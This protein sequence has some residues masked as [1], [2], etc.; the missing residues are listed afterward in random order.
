MSDAAVIIVAVCGVLT[1]ATTVWGAVKLA[2][3][4]NVIG[5]P[6][7]GDRDVTVAEQNA[8]LL[9]L[10]LISDAKL[11]EVAATVAVVAKK[12][13]VIPVIAATVAVVAAKVD[14]KQKGN[15]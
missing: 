8:A 9:E 15:P 5:T 2:A 4:K 14:E 10:K 1:T 12:V 6:K 13:E 3:L 7:L 11:A